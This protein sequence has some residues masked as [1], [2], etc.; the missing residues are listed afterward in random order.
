[1]P[2]LHPGVRRVIPVALRRWRRSLHCA[3]TWREIGAFRRALRAQ[4]YDFVL[5]TQGLLKRAVLARLAHGPA[6]GQ[7]R[8]TA[9]EP[10]LRPCPP[11][12]ARAPR[13]D[14]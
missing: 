13:H 12:R 9:R 5:D 10:L 2:A 8:A 7:D 6:H 14:A 11:Y 1:M 4:I 3:A